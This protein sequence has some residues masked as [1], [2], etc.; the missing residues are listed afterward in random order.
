[1]NQRT[2]PS[3][4]RGWV[5]SAKP[6][7]PKGILRRDDDVRYGLAWTVDDAGFFERRDAFAIEEWALGYRPR[8][9]GFEYDIDGSQEGFDVLLYVNTSTG[10]QIRAGGMVVTDKGFKRYVAGL[11]DVPI[12]WLSECPG[13]GNG[14]YLM[15][16]NEACRRGGVLSAS[17]WRSGF[18]EHF[19]KKQIRLGRAVCSPALFYDCDKPTEQECLNEPDMGA[20]V[21]KR[22]IRELRVALE[23]GTITVP[24]YNVLRERLPMWY[25]G[26]WECANVVLKRGWCIS[27]EDERTLRGLSPKR[28]R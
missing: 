6:S 27:P 20:E 26:A 8:C 2:R 14:L 4:T 28:R 1:M 23:D 18:A 24:Q 9:F 7:E 3:E 15:A 11:A 16:A 17:A 12:R 5:K 21:F 22:P 13:I 25:G 10:S 19:W